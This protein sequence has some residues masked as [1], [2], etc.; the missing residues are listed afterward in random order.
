MAA[1]AEIMLLLQVDIGD[2]F[3]IVSVRLW[4]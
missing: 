3:R 1:L 2:I 4:H